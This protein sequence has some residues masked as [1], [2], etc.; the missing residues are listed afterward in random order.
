MADEKGILWAVPC[1]PI[2]IKAEYAPVHQ[3]ITLVYGANKADCSEWIGREFFAV[4][5]RMWTKDGLQATAV[6][7]PR[8]V[9][10]L[11]RNKY[12]HMT[13]ACTEHRKPFESNQLVEWGVEN[14]GE[15]T[16]LHIGSGFRIEFFSWT[17]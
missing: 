15:A 2:S 11:C 3:H 5:S 7:L 10:G 14:P 8:G 16:E 1:S 13:L 17:K 6:M 9:K 4:L 12:P